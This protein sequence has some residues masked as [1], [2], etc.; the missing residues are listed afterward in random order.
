[1]SSVTPDVTSNWIHRDHVKMYGHTLHS[2]DV[3]GVSLD[4]TSFSFLVLK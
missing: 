2:L 4:V 3:S 1:M